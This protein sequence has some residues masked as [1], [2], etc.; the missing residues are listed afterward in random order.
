[1]ASTLVLD[2]IIDMISQ[3][4][5][6]CR[7]EGFLQLDTV[8]E[9]QVERPSN[10][11]H[12]DFAT[13]LPLRL[14]RATRINPLALAEALAQNI[15]ATEEVDLVEAA[16][17]GFINFRLRDSWVQQQV[18]TVRSQGPEYGNVDQ[19][20]G[21][22]MMVEFVSVNPTGPVH[23]G[24]T[25]GA[26]L[27]SSLANILAA[28]GYDVTREY[29]VNDAGG[30]M[31]AFYAS[32]LARYKQALGQPAEMPPNGYVGE[33]I[34]EL[35]GDI[36]T[37]QGPRFADLDEAAALT[38]I[39]NVSR[40][41]MVA[42]IREDLDQI[43]VNFDNWFSEQSLHD[44]GDF[45]KGLQ[46]LRDQGYLVE[47]ENALWFTSTMLGDDK[48]NVVIRSTGEPTYFAADIAYHYNKFVQ[49]N[50]DGVVNIW[51][52]DHQG[53]VPRMKSAVE[54][55]GINPEK[56]TILISQMVTLKRG[57]EVVRASKR[58]GDFVSLRELSDEVGKDACRY[59][60]LARTPSTQMEFDLELAK[61]ESNENPVYYIQYAHARNASIMKLARSRDIDWSHGDVALLSHPSELSLIRAL[62]RLPE[63]VREMARSLEPHH[64]PHYTMELAT[65]FHWFYENCRVVS[66]NPEDNELTLARLKLVESAQIVFRRALELMGMDAPEQ[67]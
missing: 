35:A 45:D 46:L 28:A 43:G 21:R 26:V 36:L 67:M 24:H 64:L 62:L 39:G 51:G 31:R 56:L 10:P 37:D 32:V 11:Q 49:R 58:T 18:E 3:A 57:S 34:T 52:A 9:I 63:L 48:D 41:K 55:L 30:Q 23:V 5:E 4:V 60:F 47:R 61:Q 65:A 14:A 54:A 40:E 29:Y 53:H 66:S 19:G 2:S 38:E 27:G 17:P 25:R 7:R 8:P 50:Y 22:R 59:F 33:Y 15:P 13:S 6:K 16:A 42:L 20:H 12:G 1:M 44:G